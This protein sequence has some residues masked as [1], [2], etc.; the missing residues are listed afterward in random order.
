M[1]HGYIEAEQA[2]VITDFYDK[3]LNPYVNFHR[4]CGVPETVSLKY[5]KIKTRY[6]RAATPL[7]LLLA[8]PDCQQFL[9]PGVTIGQLKL[10][11]AAQSDTEAARAMQQAKAELFARFDQRSA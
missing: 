9:R 11:A 4:P 1:G 2:Q 3:H 5:G 10:L 8:V 7:E 6:R